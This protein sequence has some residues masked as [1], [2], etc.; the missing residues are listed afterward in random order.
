[1]DALDAEKTCGFTRT[2]TFIRTHMAWHSKHE[3]MCTNK[4]TPER[5]QSESRPRDE[6]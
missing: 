4:K 3:K 6:R 1:M 5:I 2:D